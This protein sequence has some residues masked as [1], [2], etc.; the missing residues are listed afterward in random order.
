[1]LQLKLRD[2]HHR[3]TFSLAAGGFVGYRLASWT[4]LKYTY[5]GTYLQG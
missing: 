1:M 2:G 5:E 4:K 3:T